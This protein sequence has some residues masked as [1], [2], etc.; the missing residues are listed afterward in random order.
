MKG[1]AYCRCKNRNLYLGIFYL[2][3]NK[4][5]VC[6]IILIFGTACHL[7]SSEYFLSCFIVF[8]LDP[9]SLASVVTLF[10]VLVT[11]L[12]IIISLLIAYKKQKI[13]FN[14]KYCKTTNVIFYL[15]FTKY[16]SCI[17]LIF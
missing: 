4:G 17:L 15:K 14:G 10:L 8:C 3:A 1:N 9:L 12:L 6:M 13:Y 5:C 11:F 16:R 2:Q 7:L